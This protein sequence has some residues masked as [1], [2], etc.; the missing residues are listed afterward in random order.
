M[1]QPYVISGPVEIAVDAVVFREDLYPRLKKDPATAQKYAEDLGVLPPIEVN[2][3]Y[4]LIDGWHRWTAHKKREATCILA[5][6]TQTASD[7]ELL[8]LAIERNA[9]H[10]LQLSQLDKQNM[11]RFIYSRTPLAKQGP[12]KQRIADILSVDLT[13]VQRWLSRIDKDNREQR[14]AAVF[15]LWLAYNTEEQI[16]AKVGMPRDTVHSV[17][18]ECSNFRLSTKPGEFA[19]DEKGLDRG[20]EERLGLIENQNRENADH[21][22]DFVPPIYNIWKQQDKTA[23]VSHFGNS[24]IRW[25][26]NLLYLYTQPFDVVV[27]PFAGGGSTIDVCKKRLRRYWVSDRRPVVEREDDIRWHDITTGL[28]GLHRWQDVKLVY[29]DPPYWKQ[30]EGEYSNDPEDLANMPL[31]EFT[32]T[33][34]STI[35]A[36]AK[37]LK[38]GAAIALILQPTQW[39]APDHAYTDHVADMLRA[40]KLPID[41]RY[42]VPYE[43]QQYN[44]QMVEW[45]KANR[46]CLVLTREIVVWKVV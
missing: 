34:A 19:R 17:L 46:R 33:L 22:A 38:S 8:E 12:K 28:P 42:S 7:A 3:K 36:F 11:A 41:M 4:E 29:L 10:G 20:D 13:T 31:E 2:Q 1:T 5:I 45:A 32:K 26:D 43:S 39:N 24:E 40:V 37:K 14:D 30:A 16:A 35:T 6:V 44:A 27:D 23:G 9:T 25:L 18:L 15:N 21:V